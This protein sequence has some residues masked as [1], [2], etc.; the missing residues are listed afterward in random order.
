M[1]LNCADVVAANWDKLP[2]VRATLEIAPVEPLTDE[3]PV[4]APVAP[5]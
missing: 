2:V 1:L 3:T 5:L 4:T